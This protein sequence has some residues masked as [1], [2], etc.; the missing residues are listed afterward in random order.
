MH[1]ARPP[2]ALLAAATALIAFWDRRRSGPGV[3]PRAAAGPRPSSL[4][5]GA[6]DVPARSSFEDYAWAVLAVRWVGIGAAIHLAAAAALWAATTVLLAR[7]VP[8]LAGSPPLEDAI[9]DDTARRLEVDRDSLEFFI[10][11]VL[12]IL[13]DPG[14]QDSQGRRLLEGLV[15]PGVLRRIER[16]RAAAGHLLR[17]AGGRSWLQWESL[18]RIVADPATGRVRAEAAGWLTAGD[19][20]GR[21][22][23]RLPYRARLL[24]EE[25]TPSAVNPHRFYVVNLEELAGGDTAPPSDPASAAAPAASP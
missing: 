11:G 5:V 24:L 12:S 2:P 16:E 19:Q 18:D 9:A 14:T 3:P 22:L 7:P 8:V 1:A 10:R 6:A 23:A 20:D 17:R 25:N 13:N 4:E 15:A 21:W